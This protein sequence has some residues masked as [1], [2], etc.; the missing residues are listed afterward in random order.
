MHGS[1]ADIAGRCVANPAATITAAAMMLSYLGE[2]GRVDRVQV[3][4]RN[5]MRMG[6]LTPDL[7]GDLT[8]AQSYGG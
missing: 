2:K 4:L 1:A 7:G 3:A 8:T 6:L 5:T